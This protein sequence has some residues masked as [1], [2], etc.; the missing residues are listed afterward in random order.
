MSRRSIP[1]QTQT[2]VLVMSKRR[3]CVCYHLR[4]DD[5][6]KEGQIAHVDG[7]NSNAALSNLAW[8]CAEHHDALDSS[9]SQLKGLSKG[10]VLFARERLHEHLGT[11]SDRTEVNIFI[12]RGEASDELLAKFYI[13][14]QMLARAIDS[15]GL[16]L[17]IGNRSKNDGGTAK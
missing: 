16:R 10:E 6:Q 14:V 3:C 17:V 8:L 5:T 13:D 11:T 2:S 7:D 4:N 9:R 12:E 1:E 15:D